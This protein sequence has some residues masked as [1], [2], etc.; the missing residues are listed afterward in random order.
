MSLAIAGHSGGAALHTHISVLLADAIAA[1]RGL[2][3]QKFHLP[4]EVCC[5]RTEKPEVA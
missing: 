1:T 2:L 5:S 4:V 3:E